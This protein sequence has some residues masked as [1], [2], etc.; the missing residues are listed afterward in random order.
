MLI[1]EGHDVALFVQDNMKLEAMLQSLIRKGLVTDENKITILG[2][3]LL[4]FMTTKIAAPIVRKKPSTKEF[5][6]WWEAFPSTDQFE[7]KGR[8]F[9]GSR[10]MRVQKEKCKLKFNAILNEGKYSA[11]QITEATK[12]VVVLKKEA[13]L[14]KKSNELTYLQN[15]YTFLDGGYF[16]PFI[17][18]AEQ[19]LPK[20]EEQTTI[21]GGTDI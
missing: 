18:L 11:K 4:E 15:S 20:T 6:D 9:T 2:D 12:Y 10:G 16:V 1:K 21:G 19:G 7:Y 5:D 8:I 14:K 17:A 3:E 13:S